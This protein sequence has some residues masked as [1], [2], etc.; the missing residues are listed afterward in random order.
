MQWRK[1]RLAIGAAV[2]L[3]LLGLTVWATTTRDRVPQNSELPTVE[4]AEDDV[5]SIEIHRPNEDGS[6]LVIVTKTDGD[7]RVT[8]PLEAEA[9][10]TSVQSALSRLD[11]LRV[12]GV[13]ATRP[14]NYAR[15]EVDDAQAVRV[16]VHTAQSEDPLVLRLGKFGGG[17]TIQ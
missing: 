4:T 12:S 11:S 8:V 15:L 7:W 14:E 16:V 13:A 1:N 6:D 9:D 3:A 2:F 10:S 5:T 17:M